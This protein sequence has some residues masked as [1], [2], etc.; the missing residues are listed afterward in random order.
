MSSLD[1]IVYNF[2]NDVSPIVASLIK[3]EAIRQQ[4]NIEL[5]AIILAM[6]FEPLWLL[7]LQLNMPKDTLNVHDI[8]D[9]KDAIMVDVK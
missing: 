1:P 3:N 4:E 8:L 5:I 6:Q 7:V 2:V 9:G